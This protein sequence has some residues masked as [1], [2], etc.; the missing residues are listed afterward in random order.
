MA[1]TSDQLRNCFCS[2]ISYA[3]FKSS[4]ARSE[5]VE[6]RLNDA[7]R[8]AA[9]IMRM[10]RPFCRDPAG[11]VLTRR[12]EQIALLADEYSAGGCGRCLRTS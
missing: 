12:E 8:Q 1:R 4:P 11:D 3:L 5:S 7:I 10:N 6:S 9:G 2:E